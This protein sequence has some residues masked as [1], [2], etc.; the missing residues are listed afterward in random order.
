MNTSTRAATG[1]ALRG[2]HPPSPLI[3]LF[4]PNAVAF[5]LRLISPPGS[6]V[7]LEPVIIVRRPPEAPREGSGDVAVAT[8]QRMEEPAD[9]GEVRI[10][11]NEL[12][13]NLNLFSVLLVHWKPSLC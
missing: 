7:V 2:T 8:R 13:L 6:L 1:G 11:D 10:W 9:S 5:S 4:A 12:Q 3:Q